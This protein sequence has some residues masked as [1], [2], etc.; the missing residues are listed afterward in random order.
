MISWIN[1]P[2]FGQCW[3][4]MLCVF[5]F[6]LFMLSPAILAQEPLIV[7]CSSEDESALRIA[8]VGRGNT[9]ESESLFNGVI[10]AC[11]SDK[12]Q[13]SIQIIRYVYDNDAEGF[14]IVS[15]IVNDA[16]ADVIIGP[17]DSSLYADLVEFLKFENKIP[18]ISPAVTVSLGNAA[19]GWFFRTNVD[20][21]SRTQA[22]YDFL[23][24][25]GIQNFAMLY[26]DSTF[27]EI[28]ESAFRSELSEVQRTHFNSFR[29]ATPDLSRPWIKQV[30]EQRP[31]AIGI[32]GSRQDVKQLSSLIKK[33]HTDWNAYNPYVFT[34]V[35]T[36]ALA[37]DGTYFLSVGSEG[38]L[39][40][41]RATGE[42]LDL[43]NDTTSLVILIADDLLKKG[44]SPRSSAWPFEFRKRLVGALSGSISK[45]PSK[46]AMEFSML[47]NVSTPKVMVTENND[48]KEIR[49]S[50]QS[51]WHKA[52]INWLEIRERRFGIAPIVNLVLIGLIVF[53][54]T[55]VDLKKS[56]RVT[57]RDLIRLPFVAL[58]SL[59]VGLAGLLFIYI[60][61]NEVT[62][63]D[64]IMGALLV[65]FGYSGL[66][67]T[68]IF[69]TGAGKSIGLRRYY[70]NLVKW[71]YKHIRKQQFE[72]IGPIIN[73]IAYANSRPYL[74]STILESYSFAGD[75]K[76]TTELVNELN[77]VLEKQ[78]TTLGKRKVLSKK[79]FRE[80]SWA[81]LQERRIVP[82]NHKPKDLVDPEPV[83]D[84]AVKYSFNNNPSCLDEL[85]VMV[86]KRLDKHKFS[87]LKQEFTDDI[88]SSK[89]PKAKV[90][91]C[92]RWLVLL[93]G[94]DIPLLVKI[95]LLPADYTLKGKVEVTSS[96]ENAQFRCDEKRKHIRVH[97]QATIVSLEYNGQTVSGQ[98][99]DISEGGARIVLD[100]QLKSNRI[101]KTKEV[102]LLSSNNTNEFM[103]FKSP[104]EIIN[105]KQESN[106]KTVLGVAW[107]N[108]SLKCRGSI[109]GYV[110]G[111]LQ[112]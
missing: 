40:S 37:V 20:A 110:R 69:E 79:I 39:E 17:S 45:F 86:N 23:V 72:K 95:G 62:E 82:R 106:L 47:R 59:N 91:S 84:D 55:V 80:L 18:I 61:E 85:E 70:E 78:T 101:E 13:S 7:P 54:L 33:L 11:D 100:E 32:I 19:E 57:S 16:S 46:T 74:H 67:K 94:F 10:Q 111:A 52:M 30:K 44:I 92:I 25:K 81:K 31:E 88:N 12:W 4:F 27:G 68:T 24:T 51:G 60:A 48:V 105:V 99:I 93:L 29:F 87:D 49:P 75:D 41:G 89:T 38:P 6:V 15:K 21:V 43:S 26:T 8:I 83:V 98:L 36:R 5:T 14:E 66:L 34:I 64:S 102:G 90:A 53:V 1:Y 56:H 58:I 112:A 28:A 3:R 35:D 50:T 104:I 73:Y 108:L 77:E 109:N 103:L 76:R 107:E 63:W 42:L 71:I 22:M 9:I 2:C 65:A 97:K 96:N